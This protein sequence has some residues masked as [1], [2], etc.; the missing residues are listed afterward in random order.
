[1]GQFVFAPIGHAFI[2]A[3]GWQIAL[4]AAGRDLPA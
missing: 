4:S 2:A 3:Y 1:M